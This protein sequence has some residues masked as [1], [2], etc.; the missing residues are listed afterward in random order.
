MA[1][2]VVVEAISIPAQEDAFNRND[3]IFRK[4]L[5]HAENICVP[6]LRGLSYLVCDS[7]DFFV[8]VPE[9]S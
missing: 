9:H 5:Y 1:K 4:G 7:P 6:T 2:I 8:Y 3:Y